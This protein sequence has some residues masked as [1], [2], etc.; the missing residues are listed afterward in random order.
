MNLHKF[1]NAKILKTCGLGNTGSICYLNSLLQA[2]LSCTSL[3]EFFLSNE[4]KFIRENNKMAIEYIKVIKSVKQSNSYRDVIQSVG[5]ANELIAFAQKREKETIKMGHG[6]EDT[7]QGLTMF[8]E[9]IDS[10]ELYKFFMY[11]Y[12]VKIWCLTCVEEISSMIDESCILEV[13]LR[14]SGLTTDKSEE[15]DPLNAHI[16]QYIS[17]LDDYT[18]L[19]CKNKKCCRVYQLTKVPEIITIQFNKFY[20]KP[21]V[22]FPPT[23]IFPALN[24]TNINYKIVARIEHS[25]NQNGGHYWAHCFRK[26]EKKDNMYCLNDSSV[27]IGTD[28][29]SKETYFVFYH[30]V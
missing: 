23:L 22:K 4:E 13:P 17:A 19:K 10:D 28:L 11:K 27:S 30:N 16:R 26:G 3:T 24:N 18:C 6:Q 12:I 7:G 1:N 2:L 20:E 8:L 25:G 14:F 5:I 29:P 15:L 21:T 9:A